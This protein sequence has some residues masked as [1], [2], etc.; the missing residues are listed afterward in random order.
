MSTAEAIP[1]SQ[2][3]P[4]GETA[5]AHCG[6]P[7]LAAFSDGVSANGFCCAGCRTAYAIIH[8]NGLE[9]YYRLRDEARPVQ[10]KARA[11]SE[12][13]HPAY[14][15]LHV[16]QSADGLM[17]TRFHL[18]GVHCAACVWL[19]EKL[20]LMLEGVHRAE[21]EIGRSLATVVW[22]GAEIKLSEF[23]RRIAELGY[24]PHPFRSDGAE[25]VRLREDRAMLTR[26][27]VA[28]FLAANV[29]LPSWALYAGDHSGMQAEFQ[30]YFRWIGALLTA[31]ALAGPGRLFFKGAWSALRVRALHMDLPVAVGLAAGFM[32]GTANTFRGD[33]PVYFDCVATL[34]FL[35]LSGRFLQQ[36]FQRKAADASALLHSL[37]PGT[38]IVIEG[39]ERKE[40]PSAALL[41]GMLMEV[42]PGDVLAADGVIES[43]ASDLDTSLMTG[44]S[45]PVAVG[46]GDLVHAGAANLA[47]P[48][49]VR[50]QC[51]GEETRLGHLLRQMEEGAR[52]RAP[53]AKLA[54][55][56]SG[57]FV[58]AVM[59]LAAA[60]WLGWQWIDPT[61]AMDNAIAL[62][63]VTCPC[64][65]ALAT[66]LAITAAIGRAAQAGIL[67][68]GGDALERLAQPGHLVLDK[69]GTVTEGR[70]SLKEW[71][72]EDTARRLVLAVERH[73][74]H[75]VARG[76]VHA[77]PELEVPEAR[78]VRSIPGGGMEGLVEG[79]R[80]VVGSPVFVSRTLTSPASEEIAS[81]SNEWTANGFTPVWISVDGRLEAIAAFEDAVRSD[82]KEAI[83]HIREQ[84]WKVGL[85]SG[86]DP[87]ISQ[88][89]GK[90]LGMDETEIRGGASPEEKQA[91]LTRLSA[92]GPTAMAGDGVNDAA[93][94]SAA[95]VGIGMQG[96][97]EASLAAADVHLTRP[98]LMSLARLL[99]GAQRTMAL[100][101]RNLAIS[102][103]YNLVG[104]SLA[105]LGLLHPFIAALLMPTSSL[106]VVL[107]SWRGHTFDGASQ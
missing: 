95:G 35:L 106:T 31:V 17:E 85:L 8:E 26:I 49:R 77:W 97:A 36:R 32:Q 81:R 102:L 105:M 29:M 53:I 24:T 62:L 84:G 22:D 54:D 52:R 45:R 41:P 23:A 63:I 89:V 44:E 51:S 34:V 83:T 21:L 15:Q 69:T 74:V 87:A 88:R 14:H 7:A 5:C 103:A 27:G 12:L 58:A 100:I 57:R 40:I 76:F 46:P 2:V 107:S 61:R 70:L 3:R 56:M 48:L 18:E 25:S 99:D 20:P 66:P 96:G 101:R 42:R 59:L 55:R 38:A 47:S 4:S 90:S 91:W 92:N 50:V 104:A 33:G 39:E 68:K 28:G 9:D 19:V 79:R 16:R 94:M 30:H 80:V 67:I 37:Q 73:A 98:G 43:G 71:T 72:G 11:Y 6:L 64:A 1:L 93:A 86:D 82:A 75:P 78:D 10:G 60:T 13:D 65:L